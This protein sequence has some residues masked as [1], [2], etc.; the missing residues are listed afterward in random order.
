M[1]MHSPHS[2]MRTRYHTVFMTCW[3]LNPTNHN[4]AP[5]AA[6]FKP[7]E[8]KH[9][10]CKV[11]WNF[12]YVP[13]SLSSKFTYSVRSINFIFSWN[14]TLSCHTH[15]FFISNNLYLLHGQKLLYTIRWQPV[16]L[17][18]LDLCTTP[19][20]SWSYIHHLSRTTDLEVY[21][22]TGALGSEFNSLQTKCL[23]LKMPCSRAYPSKSL[24]STSHDNYGWY[25]IQSTH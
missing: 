14:Y 20:M 3:V 19:R 1:Q 4:L 5:I 6:V 11:W 8:L 17:V 2:A 16:H 10:W 22:W 25:L 7:L 21:K 9:Y 13:L 18:P 23:K 12:I 24:S 15:D